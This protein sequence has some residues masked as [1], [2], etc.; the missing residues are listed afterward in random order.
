MPV[1]PKYLRDHA[2][3]CWMLASQTC[4]PVL[5][6]SLLKV[7]QRSGRLAGDLDQAVCFQHEPRVVLSRVK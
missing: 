5:R 7:A 3:R 6:M 1:D 4:N 2:T